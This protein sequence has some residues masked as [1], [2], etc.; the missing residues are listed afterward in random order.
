MLN[1]SGK[2]SLGIGINTKSL[3]LTSL[4]V[5]HSS[6]HTLLKAIRIIMMS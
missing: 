5:V 3:L 2:L 6:I 4:F 1:T